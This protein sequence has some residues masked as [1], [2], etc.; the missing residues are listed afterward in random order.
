MSE[1][2]PPVKVECMR[3]YGVRVQIVG[4][5]VAAA[6]EPAEAC[7]LMVHPYDQSEAGAKVVL[8]E[9]R[10]DGRAGSVSTPVAHQRVVLADRPIIGGERHES[11]RSP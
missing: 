4:E 1:I 11:D 7:G 2:S 5:S 3:S 10:E 8:V 6:V 9:K